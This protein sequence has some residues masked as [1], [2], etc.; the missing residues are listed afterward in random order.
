MRERSRSGYGR[1]VA[2]ATYPVVAPGAVDDPTPGTGAETSVRARTSRAAVAAAAVPAVLMLVLGFV[3]LDRHSMWRDEAATLVATRRSPDELWSMLSHLEAVHALYYTLLQA[4]LQPA[5]G[6]VWAR[7]PS[8]VAMAAAAGL[9]GVLGTRLVSAQV[10]LVAGLL[11]AVNPSVSFYAQEARSTALVVAVALLSTWLLL[12]AVER[13]RAWWA[14]YAAASALLVGLNLLACLVLVAHAVTLLGWRT[15]GRVLRRAALAVL[16]AVGVAVVLVTVTGR[17]PYQ[18]GWIPRPGT[19]SA[20]DFAHLALGPTVPLVLLA[21]VLVVVGAAAARTPSQRR[22][23]ALAVPLLVLPATLL[24]A[25]SLVQPV[26]VPRYVFPS[27]AAAALLA[28]Q[29]LV[30]LAG[31]VGAR[32]GRRA[33]VVVVGLVVAVV[34]LG[35]AGAQRL[36]R[37]AASRPDDLA[38]AA[39][40]VAAGARPGDGLLFLPDNRRLVALVYPGSFAQVHD[41]ALADGPV[42]A[43]NLTGRPLP[44]AAVLANLEASPRVWVVGRPG[45]APSASEPDTVAETALLRRSF[46]AV[47]RPAVH[48]IGITLY[49]KRPVSS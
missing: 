43:R 9:V 49:V 34:V 2:T 32:A 20:R 12:Q 10:G 28:A 1:R 6:V 29:G 31:L 16:P 14:A 3:G 25:V 41:V 19:G 37:T 22:L 40:A 33:P 44:L 30:V 17:Q 21:I 48:G 46:V 36:E 39:A 13:R 23:R 4:W 24:L 38:A 5:D 11:F 7:V 26:F 42:E 8:A 18:L 27:V 35:G 45:L 15:P 47:E